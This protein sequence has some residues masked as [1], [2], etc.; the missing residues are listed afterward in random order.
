MMEI[1]THH[2]IIPGARIY[3]QEIGAGTPIIFLHGNPDSGDLWRELAE[4]LMPDY[5]CI[6][7]DLPSFGRSTIEQN[8][9]FSLENRGQ[10]VEHILNALGITEQVIVVVHD[11]GGPFGLG[12]AAAQISKGLSAVCAD[13]EP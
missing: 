9:D 2:F 10:F 12:R 11:H 8:Y 5:R 13:M 7:P 6:M 1:R 4:Q 3:V